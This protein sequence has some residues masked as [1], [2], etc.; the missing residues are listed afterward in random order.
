M[1]DMGGSEVDG[2]TDYVL[3]VACKSC[4][5]QLRGTGVG[6]VLPSV[7]KTCR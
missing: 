4:R 2:L 3:L 1:K 7:P 5:V 6:C